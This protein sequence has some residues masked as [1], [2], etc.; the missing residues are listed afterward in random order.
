MNEKTFKRNY[1]K[2]EK[3]TTQILRESVYKNGRTLR[4]REMRFWERKESMN[5]RPLIDLNEISI[6][7]Q[8]WLRARSAYLIKLKSSIQLSNFIENP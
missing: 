5:D 2:S 6:K 8:I 7:K 1:I 3:K 4:F